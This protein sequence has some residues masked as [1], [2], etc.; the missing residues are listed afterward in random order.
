[1]RL[2]KRDTTRLKKT[3]REFFSKSDFK[4]DF[5]L[6]HRIE[7]SKRS[8]LYTCNGCLLQYKAR[9]ME[10]DHIKELQ[11]SKEL[12]GWLRSLFNPKNIQVL[13]KS[14]HRRKT[15]GLPLKSLSRKTID[16]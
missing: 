10:L 13:C 2:G 4:R 11:E 15:L 6:E 1:M 16:A 14:C 9:V 7:K 3:L 5:F 12:V 8:Y